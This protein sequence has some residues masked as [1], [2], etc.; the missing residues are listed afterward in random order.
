MEDLYESLR[1]R[2]D[3]FSSGYPATQSGIELKIL[4]QLY[5]EEE[6]RIFLD[7]T[8]F[9]E[10]PEQLSVRLAKDLE[11]LE[12]T[13][14]DMSVKGLIFRYRSKTKTYYMPIPFVVGIMEFQVK[15]VEA[16]LELAKNFANY[17]EEAFI[18]TMQALDTPHHRAI[19]INR[20][21]VDQWPIAIYDDAVAILNAQKKIAVAPCV[22]RT[23][24][25]KTERQNCGKPVETC[26]MFGAAAD[27]YIENGLGREIKLDEALEIIKQ[28]DEAGLIL[29][30]ANAK[31]AGAICNCCGDC[32]GMI[33]SLKKQPSPAKAVKSSYYA[34]IKTEE[35]VGCG[36][37]LD[38]C[39]MEAIKIE[40]DKAEIDLNRCIGC[41]LCV[42]KCPTEAAFLVKKPEEDLYNPPENSMEMH[43][44][45]AQ[46]RG[47]M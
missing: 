8:H 29:Q 9:P 5:S 42:T 21:I 38:R 27:Y 33:H 34:G 11:P 32:C 2:I 15:R 47:F 45:M 37:C 17:G 1:K 31:Q 25:K 13:L 44:R 3:T 22:C 30:P 41:G 18:A 43:I 16:D 24:M 10:T 35:C 4:R 40:E 6:A 19:P 26:I 36:I 14:Y 7:L 28:S 39:Q 46:E 12:K 20:D 23:I